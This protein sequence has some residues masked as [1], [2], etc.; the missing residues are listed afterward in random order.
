MRAFAISSL[1]ALGVLARPSISYS[2]DLACGACVRSGNI[3]CQTP[4]FWPTYN[5]T[6]IQNNADKYENVV[7]NAIA[8]NMT[9]ATDDS[10]FSVVTNYFD[11]D[12]T[13]LLDFCT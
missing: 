11:D 6:C 2:P 4:K 10:S 13:L 1:L 8:Y 5:S 9:C 7:K 3:F 12:I